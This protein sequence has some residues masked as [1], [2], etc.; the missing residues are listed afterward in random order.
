MKKSRQQQQPNNAHHQHK[1]NS[2]K[3]LESYSVDNIGSQKW[4]GIVPY[5]RLIHCITAKDDA[6]ASFLRSILVET[7]KEV[8]ERKLIKDAWGIVSE[9]FNDPNFNVTNSSYPM[10]LEGF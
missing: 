2:N 10:L 7:R 3:P 5:L 1:P 8:E 6:K 9:Y 4:V